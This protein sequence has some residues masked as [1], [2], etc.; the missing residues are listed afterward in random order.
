MS[1][2]LA[3]FGILAVTGVLSLC[4]LCGPP[5]RVAAAEQ[6]KVVAPVSVA[7]PRQTRTRGTAMRAVRYPT[8]RLQ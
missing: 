3:T 7:V 5:A 8:T 6:A 1:K 4:D 2:S